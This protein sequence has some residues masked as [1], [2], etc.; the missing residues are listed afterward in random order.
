MGDQQEARIEQFNRDLY[1]IGPKHTEGW[2]ARVQTLASVVAKE[3]AIDVNLFA[4]S[5]PGK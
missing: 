5:P 4:K 3:G 2:V 1:G